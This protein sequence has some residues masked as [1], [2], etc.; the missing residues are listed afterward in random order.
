M[1]TFITKIS[2][3]SNS[4]NYDINGNSNGQTTTMSY[5]IV[6]EEDG[7]EVGSVSISVNSSYY[8][9]QQDED[10]TDAK[11]TFEEKLKSA[12]EAMFSTP[13]NV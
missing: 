2:S 10:Y 5:R 3:E 1:K 4:Q 12:V 9:N 13:L 11:K 8:N 7:T 6:V